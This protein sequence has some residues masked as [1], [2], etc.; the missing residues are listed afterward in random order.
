LR[1]R[2]FIFEIGERLAERVEKGLDKRVKECGICVFIGFL[3]ISQ[4]RIGDF[5]RLSSTY[6]WKKTVS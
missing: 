5:P 1:G 3:Q 2:N 6:G 4:L